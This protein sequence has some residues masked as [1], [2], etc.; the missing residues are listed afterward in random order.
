MTAR[1]TQDARPTLDLLV[2]VRLLTDLLERRQDYP[3]LGTSTYL[4][5]NSL[6]AMPVGSNSPSRSRLD[7]PVAVG[8]GALASLSRFAV[9]RSRFAI[10]DSRLAIRDP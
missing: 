6:G 3:I 10:R 7:A 4:I 8:S 2:T 5:N 9:R 1:A